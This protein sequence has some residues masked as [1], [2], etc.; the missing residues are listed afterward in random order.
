MWEKFHNTSYNFWI[1]TLGNCLQTPH[2]IG[3]A[4]RECMNAQKWAKSLCIIQILPEHTTR[5]LLPSQEGSHHWEDMIWRNSVASSSPGKF[6]HSQISFLPAL[7]PP[8]LPHGKSIKLV[9]SPRLTSQTHRD[10]S[11]VIFRFKASFHFP[12]KMTKGTFLST[13]DM[14]CL[15]S[16][17]HRSHSEVIIMIWN[18]DVNKIKP[19]RY[20][21]PAWMPFS[22]ADCSNI[23]NWNMSRVLVQE[24]Q[25]WWFWCEWRA[26]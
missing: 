15:S 6:V 24:G 13:A 8:S 2:A 7:L 17:W 12:G 19:W 11:T 3:H 10:I 21:R 5:K 23:F 9:L 4:C 14:L 20:R 1:K 25:Q 18:R 16:A 26:S 22:E